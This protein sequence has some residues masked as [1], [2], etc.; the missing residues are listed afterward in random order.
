MIYVRLTTTRNLLWQQSL[1]ANETIIYFV[2]YTKFNVR[3]ST[4]WQINL[5]WLNQFKRCEVLFISIEFGPHNRY[6]NGLRVQLFVVCD[7]DMYTKL[8]WYNWIAIFSSLS[9]WNYADKII[10]WI[11]VWQYYYKFKHKLR[12][13]Q[14]KKT[15]L[16]T[17]YRLWW[18]YFK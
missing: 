15:I 4:D 18:G 2:H 17:G 1:I 7:S 8:V 12:N 13:I 9:L 14:R 6:G 11:S 5:K 16:I 10:L 3:F